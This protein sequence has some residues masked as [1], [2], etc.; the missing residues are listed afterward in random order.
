[1]MKIIGIIIKFRGEI[2]PNQRLLLLNQAGILLSDG[3]SVT[4]LESKIE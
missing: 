1:M 2:C 3:K 4:Q